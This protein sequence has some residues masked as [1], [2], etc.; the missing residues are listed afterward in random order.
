MMTLLTNNAPGYQLTPAGITQ[1]LLDKAF[2]AS[3][4]VNGNYFVASGRD[5][6]IV[7]NSGGSPPAPQ[8]FEII[9]APDQFGRYANIIYTVAPGGFE[10]VII[11]SQAIY[12]QANGQIQL[13]SSSAN[14]MFLPI[15]GS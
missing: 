12:T 15:Q 7:W 14:I 10:C 3:D 13:V 8:T 11:T 2:Q 6:L 4:P 9:S 5:M 1:G